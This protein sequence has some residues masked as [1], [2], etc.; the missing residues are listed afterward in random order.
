M[1]KC[2]CAYEDGNIS[3]VEIG[4]KHFEHFIELFNGN[5]VCK[6][7]LCITD[8]DFI[9]FKEEGGVKT[10]AD[11]SAYDTPHI[12]KLNERFKIDNF[13]ICTQLCGGR[14]FEDELFLSNFLEDEKDKGNR[15]CKLLRMVENE[16]VLNLLDSHSF[17]FGQ[18]EAY[19][20][21]STNSIISSYI[22][23]FKS[24]IKLDG[25]NEDIYKKLFF[26]ELF[27]Y[28]AG[29]RKGD[30]A[31]NI[32]TSDELANAIVVPSYIKEGL[33]WLLK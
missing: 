19:R 14:T 31:L 27:L 11:Y 29:K 9:W 21:T 33:K 6:K 18:W 4:G 7:V 3:I 32:L 15:A 22:E 17:D 30:V 12:K 23:I 28:Y 20:P 25:A 13:L 26:A 24:A 8:R 10:F 2:G 5:A 16:G 1:E